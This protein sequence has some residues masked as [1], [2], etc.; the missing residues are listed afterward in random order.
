MNHWSL[1]LPN[2]QTQ[3][4]QLKLINAKLSHLI[5]KYRW[6]AGRAWGNKMLIDHSHDIRANISELCLNF[7]SVL[8]DPLY[9]L[10]V[11][12]WFFLLLNR[13]QDAPW[14]SPRTYDILITNRKQIPL[15]HSQFNIHICNLLHC[16]DH[17]CKI[18]SKY[19]IL[20]N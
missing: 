3:H 5:V 6:F 2:H 14:C 20:N 11:S 10:L 4:F 17:F 13:G 8:L 15:L 16:I 7:M 12:S 1:D 18:E 19:E 9:I